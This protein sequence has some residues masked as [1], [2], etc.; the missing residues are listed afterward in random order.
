M[1]KKTRKNAKS[2]HFHN[3]HAM[4]FIDYFFNIN[5][6]SYKQKRRTPQSV[7][8][9]QG[10]FSYN[11]SCYLISMS[12]FN[13]HNLQSFCH[14]SNFI[15]TLSSKLGLLNILF[16][17]VKYLSLS[18]FILFRQQLNWLM[19]FCGWFSILCLVIMNCSIIS[20]FF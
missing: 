7:Y 6:F 17:Y 20:C 15:K 2:S 11:P 16:K 19:S 9:L 3:H 14:F 13:H 8:V 4:S 1:R 18:S 10:A 5:P 12:Y